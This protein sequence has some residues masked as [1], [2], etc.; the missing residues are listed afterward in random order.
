MMNSSNWCSLRTDGCRSYAGVILLPPVAC[1]GITS[2]FS[3]V[4]SY[5]VASTQIQ[6]DGRTDRQFID[7][8]ALSH[9]ELTI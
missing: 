7:L 3:G 1:R 8:P 2:C 5:L 6:C 9:M 4:I